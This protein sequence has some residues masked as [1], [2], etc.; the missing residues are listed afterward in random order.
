[1]KILTLH[2]TWLIPLC[3]ASLLLLGHLCGPVYGAGSLKAEKLRCEYKSDPVGIDVAQPRFSWILTAA[4]PAQR[5]LKQSGYQIL[6]ASSAESLQ[7]DRGD[8]WDSGKVAG[9]QSVNVDYAG[10]PLTSEQKC[11]WKVRAWDQDGQASDWSSPS[12]WTMGL[13]KPGDW[14]AQWIG[15]DDAASEDPQIRQFNELLTFKDC[16]WVWIHGAK[17][18]DQPP[19][20]AQFR[21][22][23]EIPSDRKIVRA[24]FAISGD[25]QFH[26]SINGQTAAQGRDFRA[27]VASDVSALLLPGEIVLGIGVNN[28]GKTPN[29]A[30]LIGKL[31]IQFS[32]GEPLVVPIDNSWKA[33]R[34]APKGWNLASFDDSR[35]D[36]ASPIAPHGAAPWGELKIT[37]FNMLPAPYL[38]KSFQVAKPL[39]R[40]VLFASALGVYELH[41]NGKTLNDDVLSPGWT[42]Y[43][44]RV[45]YLGYDL[46]S[47]LKQG[48]NVLGSILGDGWYAGYLAFSGRRKYY[49]EYTRFI[50][51][52]RLEYADGTSEVVGTDASW[53]ANYGAIREGDL[54]MGCTYDSRLEMPGWDQAAF[55]D[56]GWKAAKVDG[57][58]KANLEAHPGLPIRRMQE[59]A[60]K[61]ITEPK[62]G[63]Y[64]VNLGQ[65]MVGWARVQLNGAKGQKVTVRYAEMLNPDGTV[66]VTNLRAAKATDTY[67]LD[68]GAKRAYEPYFTFHG[69]QYVELTG[70]DAKPALEDITGVVVYSALPRTGT[71]T[72]SEPL[73]ASSCSGRPNNSRISGS[74]R[75]SNSGFC[76]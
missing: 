26:L 16:S 31:V 60:A 29:P 71:F 32:E 47:S 68:G 25:D 74:A 13:L 49:G 9:D 58:T 28:G 39:K 56:S 53:K 19:G 61:A 8:R 17:A 43:G 45:H 44:K 33:T 64:V 15:F 62:P 30:G 48:E 27:P 70:L 1:M 65:N 22:V 23:I 4:N 72:C 2:S 55:D 46:T 5:G 10:A 20:A 34:R 24:A 66:Y 42:D 51:H 67:Y 37:R 75:L 76:R 38:R 52:L 40:A 14:K 50:A 57:G 6:V 69:F 12:C 21:K 59:V 63:V 41:L 73:A 11:F 3:S 7:Q 36:S 18:G 54:L 35:W